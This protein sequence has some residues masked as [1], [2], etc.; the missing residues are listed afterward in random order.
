M[1]SIV[2]RGSSCAVK[3]DYLDEDGQKIQHWE[4]YKTKLEAM[5]RKA[6]IDNLQ[7]KGQNGKIRDLAIEYKVNKADVRHQ[8][9]KADTIAPLNDNSALSIVRK[10]DNLTKPFSEFAKVWVPVHVRKNQ[11][12]PAS[13]DSIV[14]NI[15]VHINP[16]FGNKP[17]STITANDID[18]FIDHLMRKKCGGSKSYNKSADEVPTLSSGSVKKVYD[19]LKAALPVAKEWGYIREIPKTKA[20][21]V[22]YKKRKFWSSNQVMA[23]VSAIED[24]ELRLA[25]HL[26]FVCSLRP[27]EAV[28]IAI[29]DID[30]A[31][32]SLW[33]SQT[34][35]RASDK[36]LMEISSE[37][38]IR[39]FPKQHDFSKTQLILK[40]TKN[41]ENRKVFLTDPLLEEIKA[42]IDTISEGKRFFKDEYHDYGLLFCH[43]NGDPIETTQMVKRFR[44][45]QRDFGITDTID[46]QALRKS[47][48]MHKMRIS[49]F[50]YQ[51]VAS[52]GGHSPEV[53]M[54]NYDEA[55]ET[56]KKAL[57]SLLET[58]LY[59]SS[60]SDKPATVAQDEGLTRL[61]EVAKNNPEM[62]QLLI[63]A[64]EK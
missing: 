28:G 50:D 58:D 27:G 47:G 30:F 60:D 61:L 17:M 44:N 4:S 45:W 35:Q 32:K 6:V 53:L 23:A 55:L 31:D 54:S 24:K 13:Y 14:R 63:K 41:D 38:I 49:K 40:T 39:V 15:E 37:D 19:V 48:Q 59:P 64:F 2:Q 3:F 12:E 43:M 52:I 62:L 7:E 56:E 5:Q 26:A 18:M 36:A 46:M 1:A 42:M 51:T 25:V 8:R 33:V 20:P 21:S 22:T 11:L 16:Y 34:I 10:S 29:N 9:A 57:T